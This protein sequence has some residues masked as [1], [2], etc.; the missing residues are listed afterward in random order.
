[1]LLTQDKIKLLLQTLVLTHDEELNC[2][3]CFEFMAEF[4]E[5]HLS[6]RSVPEALT[7]IENHLLICGDCAEE[8]GILKASI[9]DLG[10]DFP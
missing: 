8:F 6:G 5:N 10:E 2:D 7:A 4:A 9:T 3:E 1:M